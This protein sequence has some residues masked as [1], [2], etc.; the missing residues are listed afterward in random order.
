M[1]HLKWIVL[2]FS[3]GLLAIF[4][5]RSEVPPKDV[6]LTAAPSEPPIPSN[7][8]A[9]SLGAR[10]IQEADKIDLS[11]SALPASLRGTE[12]DGGFRVDESGNLIVELGIKRY[13]DYFMATVGEESIAE[14]TARIHNAITTQ[15]DEPARSQALTILE[16]YLSYKTALYELEQQM[17]E[18]TPTSFNESQLPL[19]AERL[20]AI[21]DARRAHLSE[22][23]VE[24]FFAEDEAVDR[25]TLNRLSI[26]H[27]K[28]LTEEERSDQLV[29]LEEALPEDVQQQRAEVTQ[30]QRYLLEEE[31]LEK[32]NASPAE[33]HQLRSQE[34][35]EEAAVRLAELDEQRDAWG[36]R[37]QQYRKEKMQLEQAGLSQQDMGGQIAL[38]RG[39]HFSE[40][41]IRRV[42]ALDRI[43]AE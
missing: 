10:L 13:F 11:G 3:I 36:Q 24:A 7:H 20:E 26:L 37:L 29:Q 30:Y 15:L 35:G 34:F 31:K 16:D 12:V 9:A 23:V 32:Q 25:Y 5:W 17:G 40:I 39:Q 6:E 43:N 38:L 21:L 22:D 28:A 8:E 4:F 14:I 33:I 42:K 27:D 19:L 18:F 2:V 1:K 41:E